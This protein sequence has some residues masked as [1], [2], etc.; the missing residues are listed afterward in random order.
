M[1]KLSIYQNM[2]MFVIYCNVV[3]PSKVDKE[4][5]VRV[6]QTILENSITGCHEDRH[7]AKGRQPLQLNLS[8]VIHAPLS[9]RSRLE[10][11]SFVSMK[12]LT[13]PGR[14]ILS[15]PGIDSQLPGNPRYL[16]P[17]KPPIPPAP[18]LFPPRWCS[19]VVTALPASPLAHVLQFPPPRPALRHGARRRNFSPGRLRR[20]RG[21][22]CFGCFRLDGQRETSVL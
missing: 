22:G 2:K 1:S 21:G 9:S 3:L 11:A 18:P 6:H 20:G 4:C 13:C 10:S 8:F 16:Y 5:L 14:V 12:M 7:V 15:I 17:R 19:Y